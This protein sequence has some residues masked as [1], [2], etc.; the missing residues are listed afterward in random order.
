MAIKK[1]IVQGVEI[2]LFQRDEADFVCISDI[3]KKFG[4]AQSS[5]YT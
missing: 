2:N 5:N 1:I 4:E 3:A